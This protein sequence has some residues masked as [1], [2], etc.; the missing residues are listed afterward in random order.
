M[1]GL[2]CSYCA[3]VYMHSQ[4]IAS[5]PKW[6]TRPVYYVRKHDVCWLLRALFQSDKHVVSIADAV[7]CEFPWQCHSPH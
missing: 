6:P 4:S 1:Q 7:R 5:Y 3:S 2:L